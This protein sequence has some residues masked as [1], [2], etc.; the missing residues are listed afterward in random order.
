MEKTATATVRDGASISY[1]LHESG[2]PNAPR[3]LLVHSL[4]LD[5]TVWDGVV[6]ALSADVDIL[7]LDCRG[8]GKSSKTPGPYTT[9]LFADDIA[10][11]FAAVGWKNAVVAGASMGGSATLQFVVSYPHMVSGLG[12]IDTTAWY[13]AD[14]PK[15]W[16]ER[17]QKAK[18]EGLAS[19]IDFQLT[20]WFS[21]RFNSEHPEVGQRYK[22][23]FLENDI[24]AYVATCEMLGN[25]DLRPELETIAVP[26]EIVVGEE[27]YATPPAMSRG[28]A[29]GIEDT[30]MTIIPGA[31]HLTPGEV[32]DVIASHLRALIDRARG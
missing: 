18:A 2:K 21:D 9:K 5:R 28:L 3:L 14:A 17:G 20:R 16:S 13:G 29:D 12:C 26:A 32:P 27:D 31:R 4:A 6:A 23:I 11:L 7:A 30:H 1:S 19:L 24:D 25:F 15:A 10:D 8:H 22:A